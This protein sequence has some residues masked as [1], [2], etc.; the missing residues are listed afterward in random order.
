MSAAAVNLMCP[1]FGA[2]NGH[3]QDAKQRDPA[4]A[5]GV[6]ANILPPITASIAA[7]TETPSLATGATLR[8]KIDGN[9]VIV[10]VRFG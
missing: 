1:L 2:G 4:G 9:H 5:R 3:G 7:L 8:I 10:P 6:V